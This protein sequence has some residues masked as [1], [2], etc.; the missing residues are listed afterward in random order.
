MHY[1]VKLT[2][3]CYIMFLCFFVSALIQ[4]IETTIEVSFIYDTMKVLL[5]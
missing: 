3:K 1:K 5:S 2:A 4:I